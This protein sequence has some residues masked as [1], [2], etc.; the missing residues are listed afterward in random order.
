[1]S[2]EEACRRNRAPS[3]QTATSV[4][5]IGSEDGQFRRKSAV[6]HLQHGFH[7]V[8]D[9]LST[10]F[11]C[12]LF[13]WQSGSGVEIRNNFAWIHQKYSNVVL[14]EFRS[15]TLGHSAQSKFARVVRS[16]VW[17]PA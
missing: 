6:L 4:L 5:W 16:A 8:G 15:P 1:M 14:P 17:R 13:L 12:V 11:T 2:R 3:Q 7:H 9:V 10:K